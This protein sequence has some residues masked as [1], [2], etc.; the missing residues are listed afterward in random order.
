MP[1]N[2]TFT[3]HVS[4]HTAQGMELRGHNLTEL[5]KEANF[6]STLFLSLTGRKPTSAEEKILNAILVA[7]IDHGINPASGFV[8]RVVA[9]SG[10]EILTAMASTLLALGPYHGGAITAAMEVF[11]HLQQQNHD[12]EKAC[13][14]LVAGYRQTKKRVPGY[15]HAHY[16]DEDPRTT[17][18]FNLAQQAGLNVDVINLARLLELKIE[19]NLNRKL[20][21]NIDGAIAALLVTLGIDP[22]AGNAI[23]GV[24]RVA[25]SIAH[26]VEEQNSG[27][28]VRR[29]D[30]DQV[31]YTPDHR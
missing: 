9:A 8:P 24:A 15:G 31:N 13:A 18:L 23:F 30:E 22:K 1:Q 4:G 3:T 20:V 12:K 10:N 27:E 2:L 6:V 16:R 29:L 21:L 7:S 5:V 14:D 19:E 26:I 25:G 28:W 17:Q 11:S